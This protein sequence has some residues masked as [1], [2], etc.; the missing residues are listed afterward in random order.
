MPALGNALDFAK[1]EGRNLRAHQLG[2]APSSPVTGQLYYNTADNTLY[3]W[4]GTT[5]QSAKGGAPGGAAGGDLSGTYPNPQIAPGVIVDADVAAA[6]KDGLA[7]VPSLRTL[8]A[9]A[10]QA[11]AGNDAR[12]GAAS[13]PNGAAGGDLTGSYPNPTIGPLKIDDTKVAAANKDGAVGTPSMRTIGA[14]AT[15]VV[16]GNDARLADSRAPT[17]HR[18]THE[19]GGSDALTVDAAAATGSLRTVGL[20]TAVQAMP[21]TTRLDQIAIPTTFVSMNS[22]KLVNVANGTTANDAVNKSQLDAV[23]AGLDVKAS[24]RIASTANL[25][26]AAPGANIDGV[27]MAANDR[28]LLKDQTAP[29]ENGIWVW[30]GAAAA[31]T[32]A[33][34]ADISAEVTPGLY[35]FVEEGT[36]NADSGWVLTTNAPIVLGT[37]GLVFAQFSGAGQ[38]ISGAGLTKTGNTL[39]VGAGSGI[40]VNADNVQVANNGITNAMIADGAINVATADITGTLPLANGGTGQ[41]AAKAARETGLVASGYYTSA[42]HGAGATITITQAT[43][44]LRASRGIQVQVQDEA[45]GAVEYPDIVVA[46]TGDVTVTYGTALTAN[47]KRVTLVG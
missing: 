2:V 9:G 27:A 12:F 34:D 11:A 40:T 36:V 8:G 15:Q 10:Q 44:G 22:Q 21:G 24:V 17:A 32:R 35:T 3:W 31:M 1:Y 46:A 39:D 20:G 45:T 4:D 42:T 33:T 7:A 23:S 5:W 13:P 47:T 37:T 29:A 14:G 28:V 25:S 41:I 6:N 30:N 18:L 26:L 19:P 38:I 43:H 16:G